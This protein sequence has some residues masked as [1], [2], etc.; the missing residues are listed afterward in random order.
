MKPNQLFRPAALGALQSPDQLGLTLRAT[1]PMSRIALVVLGLVLGSALI[2]ACIIKVPIQV[3]SEAILISSKGILEL[4]IAAQ[5]EGRV[6]EVR[7]AERDPVAPGD[8][9]VR[10]ERPA[11]RLELSQAEGERDQLTQ[12]IEAINQLQIETAKASKDIRDQMRAQA[13]TSERYL[14]ER[15]A[16]LQQ[17]I[18][19]VEELKTKGMT[20][21]DR[22]LLVRSDVADTE[23]RL[24]R[25][26][27]SPLNLLLD[28]LTQKGQFRREQ[29]QLEER[30]IAV[31]QRIARLSDQLQRESAVISRDFGLVSEIKVSPGDVVAFGAP[32]VSLLP[33]ANTLYRERPGPNRLVAAVFVSAEAGKRVY[34]GM[35]ALIDPSS[36][37]RDVFGNMIGEVS[38]VSDVPLTPERMRQLL[39]NDELVRRLTAKGAPFLAQVTLQRS[40]ERPSGFVWTS[41]NGPPM[42]ITPGTLA[43]VRIVTERVTLISLVVPALKSLFRGLDRFSPNTAPE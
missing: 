23:E 9:I 36:V 7:V 4:D 11:L 8:V 6:V 35:S 10:I 28:E 1:H 40:R 5:S 30:L 20:T 17:L 43:E 14:R 41:S 2:A 26:Q 42:P 32:L 25:T 39:R 22:A 12:S 37:R 21:V 38:Y 19:G 33:T 27:S 24:S 31:Q 16:A 18:K 15:L 13:D 3:K 34:P 29:L